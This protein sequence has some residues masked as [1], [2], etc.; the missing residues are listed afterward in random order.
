MDVTWVNNRTK[1]Y[2]IIKSL[3]LILLYVYML[4]ILVPPVF[5]ELRNLTR[6]I[7]PTY[8]YNVYPQLLPF[9]INGIFTLSA[10][11]YH[12]PLVDA[13]GWWAFWDERDFWVRSEPMM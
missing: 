5:D 13:Q 9:R 1:A 6:W 2:G 8:M 11:A 4:K 3:T 7:V 10:Q 12:N